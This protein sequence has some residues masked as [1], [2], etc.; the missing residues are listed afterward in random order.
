MERKILIRPAATL[1]A[2]GLLACSKATG[3]ADVQSPEGAFASKPYNMRLSLT[4][5]PNDDLR[6]V[7]V[8][9]ARAEL[10]LNRDG[11]QARVIVARDLG[12]INLLS[13]Q[14]GVIL[15]LADLSIPD[16]V[17]VTQIR[18]VLNSSGNYIVK[19]D[20]SSCDLQ[21]PSAQESGVKLLIPNGVTIDQGYNYSLIADF[22]AKKSIVLPG[23]G[24][25][26][27]KPVIKLQSATRVV[28]GDNQGN[29]QGDNDDTIDP[30]DLDDTTDP[31][32]LSDLVPTDPVTQEDESGT[33]FD[34]GTDTS[35]PEV[36]V[37]DLGDFYM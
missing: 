31:G 13:L 30:G 36:P 37:T 5:A 20:G 9:V 1:L 2:L 4:D 22:D 18:L 7:V 24:G 8:N 14:S 11:K 35:I 25:C 32:D 23:N 27:L 26:L 6:E 15:P 21:T 12:P 17:S 3:P 16:Q 34:S 10:R 29:N 19:A 33:G 28:Q